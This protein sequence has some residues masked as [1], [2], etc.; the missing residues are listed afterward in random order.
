[1]LTSTATAPRKGVPHMMPAKASVLPPPPPPPAVQ[2]AAKQPP[3]YVQQTDFCINHSNSQLQQP[4][5]PVAKTGSVP[6]NQPM[7]SH[8]D[9]AASTQRSLS[10]DSSSS[11][12][13]SSSSCNDAAATMQAQQQQLQRQQNEDV[14]Q[15]IF[16]QTNCRGGTA[17]TVRRFNKYCDARV[18][19]ERGKQRLSGLRADRRALLEAAVRWRTS[20]Q[21]TVW[22]AELAASTIASTTTSTAA[23]A[24]IDTD[25]FS[26]TA[27]SEAAGNAAVP[28][29]QAEAMPVCAQN[30]VRGDDGMCTVSNGKQDKRAAA[31]IT[32]AQRYAN[33]RCAGSN[34]GI[35]G[36]GAQ[37]RRKQGYNSTA[38]AD[39]R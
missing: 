12:S 30:H 18:T 36:G 26:D 4:E 10:S 8:C 28:M 21:Y 19:S 27:N 32:A 15:L 5:A 38:T 16:L 2:L 11:N 37:K 3:Q 24:A 39:T 33:S 7:L 34:S 14:D 17:A 35:N 13:S 22:A 29:V 6:S 20:D 1:M 31:A 9:S 25:A 23:A